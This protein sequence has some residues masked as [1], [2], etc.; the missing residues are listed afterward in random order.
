MKL[1]LN[2]YFRIVLIFCLIVSCKE[3][4]AQTF[5]DGELKNNTIWST[6]GHP[7][8]IIEKI[9]VEEGVTLTIQ[10]GTIIK[11]QNGHGKIEVKGTMDICGTI[12]QPV[13]FTSYSDDEH[14]G[15]TNH[16]ND[17]T[18]PSPGAWGGIF[19]TPTSQGNKLKNAWLGYG[20]GPG[21]SSI[22]T[23]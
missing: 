22:L 2:K 19:Y 20:G 12:D 21:T 18:F 7:Y 6:S 5:I 11:F 9:T 8:V 13:I 15:N 23:T 16:D 1:Q 17:T 10:Q 14:G 3:I 4:N